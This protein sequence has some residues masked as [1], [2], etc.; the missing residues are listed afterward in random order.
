[1]EQN[2]PLDTSLR[3]LDISAQT[4]NEGTVGAADNSRQ[5]VSGDTNANQEETKVIYHIDEE[6]TPYKV[7]VG[8]SYRV[9]KTFIYRNHFDS[10]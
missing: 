4:D 1:M 8:E 9:P 5:G 7:T 3:P 2:N 10:I 6:E